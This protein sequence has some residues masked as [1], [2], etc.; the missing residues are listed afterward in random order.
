MGDNGRSERIRHEANPVRKLEDLVGAMVGF[1]PEK[2]TVAVF[3]AK[4]HGLSQPPFSELAMLMSEALSLPNKAARVTRAVLGDDTAP[5]YLHWEAPVVGVFGRLSLNIRVGELPRGNL[6]DALRDLRYC[7]VRVGE[8]GIDEDLLA[9]LDAVQKLRNEAASL[10]LSDAVKRTAGECLDRL[11]SAIYTRHFG[12]GVDSTVVGDNF[13]GAGR[14]SS[15]L[16][17]AARG[18]A[19]ALLR[20]TGQVC[21]GQAVLKG[22]QAASEHVGE[23]GALLGP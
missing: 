15:K 10:D 18:W 9:L 20:L 13:R 11:E 14:I 6:A 7:R 16:P 4:Q 2:E 8:I 21:Y 22:L 1:K 23:V 3:L 5:N 19:V 17:K 12:L